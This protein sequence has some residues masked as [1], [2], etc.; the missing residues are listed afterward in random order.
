MLILHTVKAKF[1]NKVVK[2]FVYTGISRKATATIYVPSR[3]PRKFQNFGKV[4]SGSKIFTNMK[5]SN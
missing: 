3:H 5:D 1:P 4:K 2:M